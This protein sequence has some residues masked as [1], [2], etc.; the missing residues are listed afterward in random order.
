MIEKRK[1][2]KEREREREREQRMILAATTSQNAT[3]SL[4]V[5]QWVFCWIIC[6]FVVVWL[7]L[8]FVWAILL[9]FEL[10]FI[11]VI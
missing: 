6:S 3:I 10:I 1:I 9:L 4:F 11:V 7:S 2:E 5:F 8:V